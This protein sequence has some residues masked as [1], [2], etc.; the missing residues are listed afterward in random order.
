MIGV[1]GRW[2]V[3]GRGWW[4]IMGEVYLVSKF[5]FSVNLEIRVGV[6]FKDIE[7]CI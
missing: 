3:I 1:F 4:W 5:L 6:I 2:V 7:L